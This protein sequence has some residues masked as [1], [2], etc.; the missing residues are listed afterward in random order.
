MK[1]V[2]LQSDSESFTMTIDWNAYTERHDDHMNESE[3]IRYDLYRYIPM[4][5]MMDMEKVIWLTHLLIID[6]IQRESEMIWISSIFNGAS[7]PIYNLLI[8]ERIKNV[9]SISPDTIGAA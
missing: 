9:Q 8:I 2:D 6:R 7:H 3:W 1:F 5:N 4:R